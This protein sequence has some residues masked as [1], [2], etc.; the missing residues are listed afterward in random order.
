MKPLP[1]TPEQRE[2]IDAQMAKLSTPER[3]NPCVRLYGK[4]PD[5]ETCQHCSYLYRKQMSKCYLKCALRENTSGPGTD[6]RAR[7]PACSKFEKRTC[8][9]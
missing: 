1:P 3:V 8:R 5:G 9:L 7:W 4:G 2:W 6:H